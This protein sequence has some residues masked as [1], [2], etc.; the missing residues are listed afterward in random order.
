MAKEK[1]IHSKNKG[2]SD[3]KH[4]GFRIPEAERLALAKAASK[5][6]RSQ[7]SFVRFALYLYASTHGHEWP[8]DMPGLEK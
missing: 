5:E 8:K 6:R 4:I 1:F 3:S 7:T 2:E